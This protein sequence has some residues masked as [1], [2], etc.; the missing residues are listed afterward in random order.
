MV[1][2]LFTSNR[3]RDAFSSS[4]DSLLTF[5]IR[6]APV[7]IPVPPIQ[8]SDLG[9]ARRFQPDKRYAPPAAVRRSA[10]RV[11]AYSG[12][13]VHGLRFADPKLVALCLRRKR[14]REVIFAKN[15]QKK[16][17]GARKRNNFWSRIS[18]STR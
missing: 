14:R 6:P 12:G 1:K 5:K 11:K 2:K 17:S 3:Q 15:K 16:G 13:P 8:L 9:D 7:L 4:L 18:C 10:A